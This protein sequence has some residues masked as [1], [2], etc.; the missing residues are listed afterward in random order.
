MKKT[1][2]VALCVVLMSIAVN[3]LAQATTTTD[4]TSTN[5]QPLSPQDAAKAK[6]ELETLAIA[7]GVKPA[8]TTTATTTTQ[9]EEHKTLG[10]VGDKALDMVSKA[11]TSISATLEKIAPH[12]WKIMIKQQYAKAIGGLV[13]PWGL[14]LITILYWRIIRKAWSTDDIGDDSNEW[15]ARFWIVRGIPFIAGFVLSIWGV[16]RLSYSIML[17]INPEYYAVRDLIT[18]LLG[19]SPQ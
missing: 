6:A 8:V 5:V 4:T 14:I 1:L 9:A 13:V 10:D 19:Q 11:V 16:T 12:V 7:F 2:L 3:V 18:M 17:L 15:W